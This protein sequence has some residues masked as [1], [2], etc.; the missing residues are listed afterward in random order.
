MA[1]EG[2]NLLHFLNV[3]W[4]KYQSTLSDS[5]GIPLI[6]RWVCLLNAPKGGNFSKNGW[7]E[8]QVLSADVPNFGIN[9][10]ELELNGARRMYFK[11]R[12]DAELGITFLET[13]DLLLRR[14]FFAWMQLAVDIDQHGTLR[15]YMEEYMPKP[16][17]FLIF[18]LDYKGNATYCDRFINVFPYD[19]SGIS[20]NYAQAGEVIKTTVKF[21][22][23]F[24]YMTEI[25]NSDAYH[26]SEGKKNV[27][28]RTAPDM[29]SEWSGGKKYEI[30]NQ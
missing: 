29:S 9:S 26:V 4:I 10:E 13:P 15:H 28:S 2:T 25:Q 6:N 19:I 22:Y 20:Y 14:F 12:N 5:Q 27:S 17:E 1:N 11:N 23:M 30:K 18:P 24:H 3:D 7:L 8:L 16:S 21:K